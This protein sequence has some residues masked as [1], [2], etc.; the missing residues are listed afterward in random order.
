M[1]GVGRGGLGRVWT[2]RSENGI[3]FRA[4]IETNTCSAWGANSQWTWLPF[5]LLWAA[6]FLRFFGFRHRRHAW[7]RGEGRGERRLDVDTC[8]PNDTTVILYDGRRPRPRAPRTQLEDPRR[9]SRARAA[10]RLPAF[11]R[12]RRRRPATPVLSLAR[13]APGCSANARCARGADAQRGR[14]A[15]CGA[16]AG[17]PE[18]VGA[19]AQAVARGDGRR[20][21]AACA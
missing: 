1:A 10:V 21:P 4:Q 7:I 16:G 13:R 11:R 9:A 15:P 5:C 14:G 19:P 2:T 6:F 18:R 3:R 8:L 17:V 12:R 20:A